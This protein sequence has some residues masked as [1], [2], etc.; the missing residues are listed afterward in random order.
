MKK[1]HLHDD[2]EH[3]RSGDFPHSERLYVE[4]ADVETHGSSEVQ[5]DHSAQH[6][7]DQKRD[8]GTSFIYTA[9]KHFLSWSDGHDW[10]NEIPVFISL[11]FKDGFELEAINK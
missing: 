7:W 9:A 8:L 1:A 4:G 3:I 10:H 11:L 6:L 2:V 5:Q